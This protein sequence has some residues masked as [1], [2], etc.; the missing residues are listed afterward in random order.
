MDKVTIASLQTVQPHSIASPKVKSTTQSFQQLLRNELDN[1]SL[2]VSKHAEQRLK[3]RE[4]EILPQTWQQISSKVQEA[5]EM[6]ITDSL[7][8]TKDAA[9]IVSAKNK[10]VITALAREEAHQQIFSNINGT[11]LIQ[12]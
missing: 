5:K 2:K 8:L 3:Q 9:L 11:I 7:V 12:D 6:G 10:T 1:N 4:I